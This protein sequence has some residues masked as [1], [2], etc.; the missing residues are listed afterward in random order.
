MSGN[1]EQAYPGEGE[2]EGAGGC[3]SMGEAHTGLRISA[4]DFANLLGHLR[5]SLSHQGIAT[6]DSEDLVAMVS[7]LEGSIVEDPENNATIYQRMGRKPGI[8]ALIEDL[9]ERML[10]DPEI[11][12]FFTDRELGRFEACMVRWICALDGPCRYGE[13]VEEALRI[14][15]EIVPCGAL[16]EAHAGIEDPQGSPISP[17]HVE[18]VVGH[19]EDAFDEAGLE[20]DDRDAVADAFLEQCPQ[21]VPGGF[22]CR[23]GLFERLGG[24]EGLRAV[25]DE[26]L[27]RLSADPKLNG[28]F[29]NSSLDLDK[30]A[31]CLAVQLAALAGSPNHSYPAA[32]EPPDEAGCRNLARAHAGLNISAADMEGFLAHLVAV[33]E[34]RG[35]NAADVEL[36]TTALQA[37]RGDV[38]ED[39]TNASTVYHRLGRREGIE[40]IVEEALGRV[41]ADEDLEGFF[42][43]DVRARFRTCLVRWLCSFDGPCRYGEGV[44]EALRVGEEIVPC[45]ELGLAHEGAAHGETGSALSITEMSAFVEHFRDA[46]DAEGVD[47]A[48]R[49][50]VV[51]I[52]ESMCSTIVPGGFG[53]TEGLY[54]RLGGTEIIEAA[55]EGLFERVLQDP[56][57]NAHFH[58]SHV[59]I[60]HI[61]A[62]FVSYFGTFPG[63]PPSSYPAPGMPPNED[64]CRNLMDA[65][66]GLGVSGADLEGFMALIEEALVAASVHP[67]DAAAAVEILRWSAPHVVSDPDSN[68]TLYQRLGRRPA[69]AAL[70]TDF[71]ERLLAHETIKGFFADTDRARFEVCLFRWICALD[72]PCAYGAG[73]EPELEIDSVPTPCRPLSSV[74]L[75]LTNQA[76]GSSITYALFSAFLDLLDEALAATAA[77]EPER[78]P[79]KEGFEEQCGDVVEEAE[80]CP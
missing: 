25:A 76:T 74:H 65:H 78:P 39:E 35:V 20:A 55:V 29:L 68:A 9:S 32:G 37:H 50:A 40:A 41:F 52:L 27:E 61:K 38:V 28:Y 19:L 53:C 31:G 46:L 72:G 22:G 10:G 23:A 48:D 45:H 51:W 8:K 18:I 54:E 69:I 1:P 49:N 16:I 33:L 75:A 7:A 12:G 71:S 6:A 34:A 15:D 60:E 77:P 26:L 11:A 80:E 63:A 59:D 42:S 66:S 36:L 4:A 73:T 79:L 24:D 13:G 43:E 14:G 30:L 57:V 47:I 17:A 67:D 5:V 64:G 70:V 58:N 62:C 56:K 44:E 2:P 21:V 3:R